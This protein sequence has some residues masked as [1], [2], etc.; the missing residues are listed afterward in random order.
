MIDEYL[1]QKILVSILILVSLASYADE[2]KSLKLLEKK[3]YKKL[4]ESLDKDIEKDS[5]NPGSYY[6]YSLLYNDPDYISNNLDTSYYYVMKAKGLYPPSDEKD[7][8]KLNKVFINDSS[9]TAQK[10]KL[11]LQ[12]YERAKD[13][14][15]LDSYNFYIEKFSKSIYNTDAVMDRNAL[16]FEYVKK[17]HTYEAYEEFMLS[18][19]GS[20]EF[21]QAK[22]QY[23]ILLFEAQT[24]EGTLKSYRAFLK[25]H[26]NSP[27]RNDAIGKIYQISTCSNSEESYLQFIKD[28]PESSLVQKAI[29]RL[30]HNYRESGAEDFSYNYNFLDLNDSI[31][32]VDF[33]DDQFVIPVFENNKYGFMNSDGELIIPYTFSDVDE[34]YFCGNISDD[35]FRVRIAGTQMVA[36]KDGQIIYQNPYNDVQDLVSGTLKILNRGKY[37]LIFKTGEELLELKYDEIVK[38]DGQ[39][40]KCRQGDRWQ[41][42]SLNGLQ[43]LAESV[44]EISSEGEF[45]MIKNE[46]LWAITNKQY[47]FSSYIDG[48]IELKF[49]YDDYELIEA[50]QVLCYKGE[51][52]GVMDSRLE[53][54]LTLDIQNIHTLPEG[55]LI[56]K[57]TIYHLYDDAFVKISGTGG[58]TDVVYKGK[59]LTGRSDEKWIL[60]HNFTPFPDVFAYDSISILSDNFVFA[61]EEENPILIFSNYQKIPL[62]KYKN[63]RILKSPVINDQNET[64]IEFVVIVYD[65]N[66]S[67]T[68]GIYG[69][70]VLKGSNLNLQLL[71]EE[72]F[73]KTY[74]GK[75]GLTDTS[76]QELLKPQ[77]QGIANYDNG[78][79]SVL[80]NKKFGIYNKRLGIYLKPAYDRLLKPYNSEYLIAYK[81]GGYGLINFKGESITDFSYDEIIYWNDSSILVK[82]ED[83]WNITELQT[84][85]IL[86]DG[87]KDFDFLNEEEEK[88][89]L[90]RKEEQFGIVSSTEGIIISPTFND[91]LNIGNEE[92]PVYFTEK[93]ISEAE[94]YIVI[95]YNSKGEIIRKQVF[96]DEEY[97]MIY[98]N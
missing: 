28:F 11:D 18:Y 7:L 15:T 51:T 75:V 92:T 31:K 30:Y 62:E 4:I 69:N 57:D 94:F 10:E 12:A 64:I 61:I 45:L 21:D 22:E 29:D 46:G 96:T 76:G 48:N 53:F 59:W 42:Y 95:Y 83:N 44:D 66:R 5:L 50:T 55:W 87:I 33:Y 38:L 63:L 24:E 74:R 43:L 20:I 98:C 80:N 1:M 39:L 72:Y 47:I 58:L 19:P 27:F 56:K 77:F 88:I 89:I 2:K 16:A 84:G 17:K 54:Q 52:E 93:Y 8:E 6:I 32:N 60:Y 68:Y 91:I 65:R 86:L 81:I 26:P 25:S 35:Y 70:L 34:V 67:E 37:G 36:S 49:I 9:L 97:D 3:D 73:K 82:V 13:E 79:V 71:G 23:Q 90:F 78:F 41:L 85:E 14:H 40:I